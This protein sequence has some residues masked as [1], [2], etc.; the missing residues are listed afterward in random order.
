MRPGLVCLSMLTL[1]VSP[2]R[3]ET[4]SVADLDTAARLRDATVAGSGAY[5][6]V[7]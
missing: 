7:A 5:E 1:A 3:A 4:L 2:V 6:I